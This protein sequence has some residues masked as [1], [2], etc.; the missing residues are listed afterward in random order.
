[1]RF[2]YFNAAGEFCI[3]GLTD[4]DG[5]PLSWD[6]STASILLLIVAIVLA[7]V[8]YTNA[9]TVV[10]L[11]A[12]ACMGGSLWSTRRQF[13]MFYLDTVQP[14]LE[15]GVIQGWPILLAM[16]YGL[17]VPNGWKLATAVIVLFAIWKIGRWFQKS[18]AE[19]KIGQL[20]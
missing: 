2:L 18:F 16:T 4:D 12:I 10:L 7:I 17:F 6:L 5:L 3:F 8:G 20:E 1:M 9:A 14:K 19:M 15:Y 13:A 11:L